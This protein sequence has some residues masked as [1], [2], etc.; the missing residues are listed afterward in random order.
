MTNQKA[1]DETRLS[2]TTLYQATDP[3]LFDFET[4]ADL[5]KLTDVIGQPRAVKAMEF[6]MGIEQQGY[7]IF[8]L[9]PT[10]T[11]KQDVI[12]RFFEQGAESHPVPS[13]WCY[14]YNFKDRHK[15]QAIELPAGLGVEFRDDM[16]DLIENLETALAS[17][18]ESEEYQ[19][20]RQTIMEEFKDRQSSTFEEL[21]RKAKSQGAA[22]I[23]T[24]AGLAVAPIRDGE[25]LSSEE[26]Q[27]LP[28]EEQERLE[29]KVEEI[30]DELQNILKKVPSWQR[31][32]RERL[33]ELNREMANFAIAGLL[34][35]LR[36][37][38]EEY[39]KVVEHLDAVQEDIV[40]HAEQFLNQNGQQNPM[41]QAMQGRAQQQKARFMHRYEVNVII[42]NSESEGAPVVYEDN[43][44]Y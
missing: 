11:G 7:N 41:A 19:T 21:Q 6:G 27:E 14:V 39:P 20:R 23:R 13:D 40:E 36:E 22:L 31:E 1:Q 29:E 32:M 37:K 10:G 26:V 15:P 35:E 4:T 44:T 43:P 24:P 17:A 34:D 2:A 30:Q 33:T 16:D 18:F 38:Y 9:G 28:E 5:E 25:V 12:R 3:D 8:A 42:D